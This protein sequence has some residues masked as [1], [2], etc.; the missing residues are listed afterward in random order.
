MYMYK[1]LYYTVYNFL[2]VDLK[3]PMKIEFLTRKTELTQDWNEKS[4][5]MANSGKVSIK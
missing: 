4:E 3:K 2:Q 1:I 5:Q